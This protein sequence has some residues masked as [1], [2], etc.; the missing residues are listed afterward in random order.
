MWHLYNKVIHQS[1]C[2]QDC[3]EEKSW[4]SEQD[5]MLL[6]C[7]VQTHKSC[8]LVRM[9]LV[10]CCL[11]SAPLQHLVRCLLSQTITLHV[12]CRNVLPFLE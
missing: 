6:V 8:L 7:I 1:A 11:F 10:Q 4:K 2:V 12:S 9:A 5:L 3:S